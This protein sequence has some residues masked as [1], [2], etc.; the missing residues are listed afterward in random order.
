MNICFLGQGK[1]LCDLIEFY[2]NNKDFKVVGAIT[3]PFNEIEKNSAEI[4]CE[5]D[6]N[7]YRS[8]YD[9]TDSFKIDLLETSNCNSE[10]TLKW[11]KDKEV[12]LLIC[13]RL[14]QKIDRKCF[15]SNFLAGQISR[16]ADR[17]GPGCMHN[18]TDL[19]GLSIFLRPA[20][21]FDR[22]QSSHFFSNRKSFS[23]D[24]FFP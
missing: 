11:L 23:I 4:D 8:I 17:E 7:L 6:F 12:D 24:N 5:K 22:K 3:E 10:E 18:S 14:K 19:L 15:R 21:F 13:F 1:N 20:I 16:N 9:V 2:L